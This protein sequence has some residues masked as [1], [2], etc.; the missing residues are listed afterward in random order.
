[1]HLKVILCNE[2]QV[3]MPVEQVSEYT[4]YRRLGGMVKNCDFGSEWPLGTGHLIVFSKLYLEKQNIS[5]FVNH[6]CIPKIDYEA[7]TFLIC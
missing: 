6:L 7:I 1:M 3:C 2:I 5:F 4:N